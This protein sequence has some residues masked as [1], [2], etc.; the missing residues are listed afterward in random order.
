MNRSFRRIAVADDEPEMLEYYC[1][2]LPAIGHVV[3]AL[4]NTGR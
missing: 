3:V 1:T 4:A 2:I